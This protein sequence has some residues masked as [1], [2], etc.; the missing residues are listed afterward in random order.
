M[1]RDGAVLSKVVRM[2]LPEKMELEHR[3]QEKKV[4]CGHLGESIPGRWNSQCKGSEVEC[5]GLFGAH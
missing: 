1:E 5:G 3:P 4:L 2:V